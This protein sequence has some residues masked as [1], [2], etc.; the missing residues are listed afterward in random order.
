MLLF[1]KNCPNCDTYYDATLNECP[2]CHKSNELYAQRDV[3]SNI[4]YFH[5]L[6]QIGLFLGG[7]AYAGMLVCELIGSL[8][9][10]GIKDE[11]LLTAVVLFFAYL[12]MAGGLL[13]IAFFTRRK[14]FSK[15]FTRPLNYAYGAG[16]AGLLVLA[17]LVVGMFISIFHTETINGNQANVEDMV[18]NYPILA[19][20]IIMLLAPICEEMTYRV[21][22]YSFLRRI[23]FVAAFIV[24]TLVFAFIHFDFEAGN[25][26][27]ELWAMPSYI[28][29]G[30][31][32]TLA[33]ELHG[34][35]CSITAH[36][37]F[38]L[39]A[40]LTIVTNK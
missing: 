9:F 32:L 7:F 21:G 11:K 5:P 15:S 40:F 19:G 1:E 34:P 4:V 33:Y 35:A 3:S 10:S 30:V 12:L 6:A 24:S 20:F 2:N 26:I 39:I 25:L 29:T 8:F 38:N 23:N 14:A 27:N 36:T 22:L 31:L 17:S 37:I 13:S 28:A 16:F 18:N